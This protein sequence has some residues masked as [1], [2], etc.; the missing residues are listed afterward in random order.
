MNRA[1]TVDSFER[2]DIGDIPCFHAGDPP[3]K[4]RN[5]IQGLPHNTLVG[6]SGS[7]AE[8]DE[9]SK[10][11]EDSRET[12]TAST[13][14]DPQVCEVGLF[15][16]STIPPASLE[17]ADQ[18]NISEV[19]ITDTI[20]PVEKRILR[21]TVRTPVRGPSHTATK[22]RPER[23]TRGKLSEDARTRHSRPNKNSQSK[24]KATQK[25]QESR[26]ESVVANQG[27]RKSLIELEPY[28]KRAS[29]EANLA[30]ITRAKEGSPEGSKR[31]AP[32][33]DDGP[34]KK[35]KIHMGELLADAVREDTET[36]GKG[37]TVPNVDQEE[38]TLPEL[39]GGNTLPE[40]NSLHAKLTY[41]K[42][43]T[44]PNLRSIPNKSK[45]CQCGNLLIIVGGSASL[46]AGFK[47]EQEPTD[48]DHCPYSG[49]ILANQE[50]V[51]ARHWE[52][53][54]NVIKVR[55]ELISGARPLPSPYL[56]IQKLIDKGIVVGVISLATNGLE[57]I[58]SVTSHVIHLAPNGEAWRG[59]CERCGASMDLQEE[60]VKDRNQGHG[61]PCSQ[62]DCGGR[63]QSRN[64]NK[65]TRPQQRDAQI[66]QEK[67]TRFFVSASRPPDGI[68]LLGTTLAHTGL[69]S[70]LRKYARDLRVFLLNDKV[71]PAVQDTFKT[72]EFS[73]LNA[74]TWASRVL[75]QAN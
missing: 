47:I 32:Y 37:G 6:P 54:E 4:R 50:T 40:D 58:T 61:I 75:E 62:R 11:L 23:N 38:P 33:Q 44:N 5:N 41:Q 63:I 8:V 14:P 55:K 9:T 46:S 31:K 17:V 2:Q 42:V 51:E 68:V 1:V 34:R 30:E 69:R 13:V 71:P 60:N 59:S 29:D 73:D 7:T 53:V 45:I 39:S 26:P 36:I 16:K 27:S 72:F 15:A 21:S 65:F 18:H 22:L 43:P 10:V 64:I 48:L 28:V 20:K 74:E 35:K 24:P 25:P 57:S 3:S 56:L 12:V 19:S 66:L 70:V 49:H 67:F 52:L